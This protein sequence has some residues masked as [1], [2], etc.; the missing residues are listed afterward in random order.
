[1]KGI[2]N[3]T[4][5]NLIMCQPKPLWYI[6]CYTN[7]YSRTTFNYRGW[8]GDCQNLDL[9]KG[10]KIDKNTFIGHFLF[11]SILLTFECVLQ[12]LLFNYSFL[13]SSLVHFRLGKSCWQRD[14][15]SLV[16]QIEPH[17]TSCQNPLINYLEVD[18]IIVHT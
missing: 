1:M 17:P 9:F 14:S 3:K 12:R 13:I 15:N 18:E 6:T 7:L 8:V 11:L 4:F 2:D 5:K 16:P 10:L